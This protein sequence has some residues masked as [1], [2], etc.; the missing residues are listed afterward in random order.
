MQGFY[1]F[2]K[3]FSAITGR[4]FGANAIGFWAWETSKKYIK[5]DKYFDEDVL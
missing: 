1:G 2:F 5:L 3:G 4:A